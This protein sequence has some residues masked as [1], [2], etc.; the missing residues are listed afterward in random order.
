MNNKLFAVLA[1][2][3][4]CAFNFLFSTAQA[5]G[6]GV[7]WT[8]RGVPGTWTSIVCSAD[9]TKVYAGF[10]GS[11]YA[12]TDSGVTWA[13]RNNSQSWYYV[14][15]S[16]DGTK[17]VASCGDYT[18]VFTSADSGTNFTEHYDSSYTITSLASSADGTKLVVAASGYDI[19][20]STNSGATWV[21]S[22]KALVRSTFWAGRPSPVRRTEP[23]LWQ[24]LDL[25]GR[26]PAVGSTSPPIRA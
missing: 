15:C 9:G 24:R 2:S 22:P 7:T 16:A 13:Q 23:K 26:L 4:L 6:T 14:T 10:T 20:T 17:L 3:L 5:Q 21:T 25:W 1:L 18:P 19:F 8:P 11:I 12:S